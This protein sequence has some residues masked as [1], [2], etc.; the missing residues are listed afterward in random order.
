MSTRGD[1]LRRRKLKNRRELLRWS[2]LYQK[3]ISPSTKKEKMSMKKWRTSRKM[4]R[5]QRLKLRI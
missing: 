1:R 4:K 2:V 3:T 5:K